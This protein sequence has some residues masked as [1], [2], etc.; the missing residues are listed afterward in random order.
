MRSVP[1]YLISIAPMMEHTDRF[2]R[3]F[4]RLLTQKTWLYTEMISARALVHGDADVHLAFDSREKPVVLQL[5]GSNADELAQS[6]KFAR[7]YDYDE[8]NLNVGC[9]SERVHCGGFGA[10]LMAHGEETQKIVQ[11]MCKFS[12]V[13]I[14]VKCRIGIDGTRIGL[15]LYEDYEHLLRFAKCMHNAGSQR[16]A[17]HARIAVLGG[18]SPK[19]NREIPPLKH[20]YVWRLK[21]DLTNYCGMCFVE[22]NGGI[23]T[24]ED[25]K[26]HLRSVDAVMMGRAAVDNPYVFSHADA[27]IDECTSYTTTRSSESKRKIAESFTSQKQK[28][29]ESIAREYGAYLQGS[30]QRLSRDNA[31]YRHQVR[32]HS[33]ALKHSMNLF[34]GL[35]GAKQWRQALSMHMH[36][37]TEPLAAIEDALQRLV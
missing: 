26:Q 28:T 31:H 11:A 20:E 5:G 3:M 29:R 9:P 34:A 24:L 17:V 27:F 2:F 13:P 36:A 35:R 10:S 15:P 33:L 32:M 1:P 8:I 19:K 16:I 25:A 7:N 23:K 14:T 37:R 6:V 22:V 12:R 4:M 21:K 30:L 18:L